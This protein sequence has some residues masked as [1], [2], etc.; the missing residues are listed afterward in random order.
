MMMEV[1]HGGL[2]LAEEV[3]T[4]ALQEGDRLQG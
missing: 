1:D 4:E 3:K 2:D